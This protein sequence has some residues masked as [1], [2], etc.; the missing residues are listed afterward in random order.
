MLKVRHSEQC[1]TAL[2]FSTYFF[3]I[4][5]T[6]LHCLIKLSNYRQ[7]TS[8]KQTIKNFIMRCKRPII[9]IIKVNEA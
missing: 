2:F 5:S 9:M 8:N 7:I 6:L 1:I 4:K 3:F